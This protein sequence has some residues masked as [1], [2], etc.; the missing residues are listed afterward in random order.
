MD[1]DEIRGQKAVGQGQ[2]SE[3]DFQK[4]ETIEASRNKE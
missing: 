4:T 3:P 1:A 2:G